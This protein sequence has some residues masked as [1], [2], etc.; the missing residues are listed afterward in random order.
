MNASIT[1]VFS[2]VSMMAALPTAPPVMSDRGGWRGGGS[3]TS[4]KKLGMEETLPAAVSRFPFPV[5]RCSPSPGLHAAGCRLLLPV[6]RTV[7]EVLPI[8][9]CGRAK[10]GLFLI[11]GR[12]SGRLR[13]RLE[14]GPAVVVLVGR[15][16]GR[17]TT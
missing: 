15:G 9:N 7:H 10:R 11:V 6:T 5:S 1:R 12:D 8:A 2:P 4:S 17:G 14:V 13:N 3:S 16:Q